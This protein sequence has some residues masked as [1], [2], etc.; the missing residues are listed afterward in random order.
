MRYLSLLLILTSASALAQTPEERSSLPINVAFGG[1][2]ASDDD[3]TPWLFG[4][5][6]AGTLA[7]MGPLAFFGDVE[8]NVTTGDR[9][10]CSEGSDADRCYEADFFLTASGSAN[11]VIPFIEAFVGGGYRVGRWGGPYFSFGLPLG[12]SGS[13]SVV[14]RWDVRDDNVGLS[15]GLLIGGWP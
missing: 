15:I 8:G 6:G 4:R 11:L 5:L 14:T 9:I 2:L 13:H 3:G 12:K 1:G 7:R 10:E